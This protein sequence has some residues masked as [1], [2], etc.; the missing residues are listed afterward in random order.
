MATAP[1]G[2]VAGKNALITG[3]AGGIGLET[4]I[5]FLREGA[6]VLMTDISQQALE[7]AVAK[8]KE[9]VPDMTGRVAI[10]QCD[11][12]KEADVQRV[13]ESL[14]EW[15][16]VDIMFNNAGIMHANDDGTMISCEWELA[17]KAPQMPSTLQRRSGTSHRTSMSK[18]YGSVA[19]MLSFRFASTTRRRAVLST[20]HLSLL[21]L[22]LQHHSSHTQLQRALF[23][24]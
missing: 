19:S 1:R 4:T 7:K 5:L 8:A 23:S 13:V 21:L 12:S 22:E 18:A 24:P 3:A 16:G 10:A 9:I 6:S 20:Q 15:G 14:D 11:V 17:N 2:R